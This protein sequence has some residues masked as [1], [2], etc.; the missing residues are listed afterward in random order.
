MSLGYCQ[1]TEIHVPSYNRHRTYG[2]GIKAKGFQLNVSFWRVSSYVLNHIHMHSRFHTSHLQG[3][4]FLPH[5]HL[6]PYM[7]I[8][9]R[10]ERVY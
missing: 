2:T 4:A 7:E 10:L 5:K 9:G 6:L 8:Y 1:D 3:C